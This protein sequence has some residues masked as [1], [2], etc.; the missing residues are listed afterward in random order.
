[1][2]LNAI[3]FPKIAEGF[4]FAENKFVLIFANTLVIIEQNT[5]II[6]I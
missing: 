1:M 3:L 2:D 5:F 6:T 4:I